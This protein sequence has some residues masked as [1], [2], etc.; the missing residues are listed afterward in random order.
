MPVSWHDAWKKLAFRFHRPHKPAESSVT[1]T[2]PTAAI[3]S[4]GNAPSE[5]GP[6]SRQELLFLNSVTGI[7][8][9]RREKRSA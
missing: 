2:A 7:D 5:A 3:A 1:T 4:E 8:A 9:P 6:M